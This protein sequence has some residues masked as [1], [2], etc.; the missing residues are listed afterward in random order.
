MRAPRWLQPLVLPN[1]AW[2][3]L[4]AAVG[5]AAIGILAIRLADPGQAARQ[6]VFLPVAL[7]AMG[8]AAVP[9]HR[10]LVDAAYPAFGLTLVMLVALLLPFMPESFVPER[11]GARRWFDLGAFQIQP[12]ELTKIA[13]VL[14]LAAYL[15]FRENYRSVR[16]LLAPF[17]ITM[18]PIGLIVVE[19]DLGT[20]TLFI[21]VLFAV[22]IVAGARLKH[23]A[24][25]V[26]IGLITLPAM[27]PLLRPHQQQRIQAM[28][29]QLQGDTRELGGI[30]FQGHK[31]QTLVGAG[32][33]TGHDAE[34]AANLVRF[35]RLPEAQNDM[36][37][38]VI[39]T[40]WGLAGGAAVLGLYALF[41]AG[42]LLVAAL[43]KEPF[44]RLVAVGI[45][46]FVFAQAFV[47]MGMTVGI[48][49]I[50]GMTL[51]FVSYGGSSLVA[52]FL[53]VGLLLNAGVRRPIILAQPSFE[54][55]QPRDQPVQRDPHMR[56]ATRV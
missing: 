4:A 47:N 25:I 6:M 7:L 10:R 43:N 30:R 55:D 9:H 18:L 12:S 2:L 36:I 41:T 16:G 38:A 23:I 8:V 53:M 44:A 51:P 1:V 20:A 46:S 32:R 28:V 48:L 42:G 33:L 45:V 40:R 29:A 26:L 15:R 35:N 21:P 5:L 19:P 13:Y 31:A 11:N 24:V 56:G 22:L 34:H 39:C 27:Y 17:V 54:Y 37:F 52:N 14:S 49:P 50:T 3:C